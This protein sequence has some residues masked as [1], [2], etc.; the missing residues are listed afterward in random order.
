MLGR[1]GGLGGGRGP[2]LVAEGGENSGGAGEG[3]A[4][5][6]ELPAVK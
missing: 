6:E 5:F 4:F 2:A 3:E 1:F